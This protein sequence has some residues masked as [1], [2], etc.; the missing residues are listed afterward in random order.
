MI[1]EKI[2]SQT[3][4]YH[5]NIEKL[6][7]SNQIMNG[8][9]NLEQYKSL[10]S[11]NYIFNKVVEEKLVSIE[12]LKNYE[13]LEIDKRRKTAYLENDLVSININ[14]NDLF[15]Y[16]QNLS[17]EISNIFE[18]IG[19]LYLLEGSTLGGSVI[20]KKIKR[21]KNINIKNFNFYGCYGEQTREKWLNFCQTLIK[22]AD[23]NE[24]SEEKILN[25][26]ISAYENFLN[27]LGQVNKKREL[28]YA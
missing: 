3:R 11:A 26:V 7:Y 19:Y 25:S 8:S 12:E 9:L 15:K 27:L 2:K 14:K 23:D 17:V 18:A 24:V 28:F 22:I 13:L 1:L 20:L 21:N 5:D 4:Q 6:A 10:I 16:E